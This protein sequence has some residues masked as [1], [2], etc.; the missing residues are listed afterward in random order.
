MK[1]GA[2]NN[3]RGL[4]FVVIVAA[5]FGSVISNNFMR[6]VVFADGEGDFYSSSHISN[7]TSSTAGENQSDWGTTGASNGGGSVETDVMMVCPGDSTSIT[8][9]HNV[10]SHGSASNVD[11]QVE[12]SGFTGSGFSVDVGTDENGNAVSGANSAMSIDGLATGTA[13]IGTDY[14]NSI[15]NFSGQIADESSRPYMDNETGSS[16]VHRDYY[17][18]TFDE[19]SAGNI[20]KFC[21]TMSVGGSSATSQACTTVSVGN[22]DGDGPPPPS[23]CGGSGNSTFVTSYVRNTSVGKFSSWSKTVYAKP[24][25]NLEWQ[26]CYFSGVQALAFKIVSSDAHKHSSSFEEGHYPQDNKQISSF[27]TWENRYS[28]SSNAGGGTSKSFGI[29]AVVSDM[30]KNSH[31]VSQGDVGAT[32]TETI[33]TG[34]PSS[35]S[36]SSPECGPWKCDS[37]D[38]NPHDCRCDEDGE[39]CDTCYDTCW[40]SCD[41]GSACWIASSR[42]GAVSDSASALVPYNF[43]H[44]SSVSLGQSTVFSGE[45]ANVTSFNVTI[46]PKYNSVTEGTYAT[47]DGGYST[48]LIGYASNT[49]SGGSLETYDSDICYSVP[50]YGGKCAVYSKNSH[51]TGIYNV[52]DVPAGKYF[53]V[54]AAVYP[55]SSGGDTNMSPTGSGTWWVS[56]PACAKIAKKPS[57]QIWGAGMYTADTIGLV[58][59]VK[60]VVSGKLNDINPKAGSN[61]IFGSW[62]EQNILANGKVSNLSS[63]AATGMAGSMKSRTRNGIDGSYFSSTLGNSAVCILSPLTMPNDKCTSLNYP[64][65]SAG[66]MNAPADKDA[67]TARFVDSSKDDFKLHN[68]CTISGVTQ[69][70]FSEKNTQVYKCNGTFTINENVV[71]FHN[72][73]KFSSLAEVPKIIIYAKNINIGCNVTQ[74]DAILIAD[75]NVNTCNNTN[76]NSQARANQLIINGSV[77]ANKMYANRTYGAAAGMNS[78]EPAEIINYDTSVYL[79]GSPRADISGSGKLETVYQTELSPRY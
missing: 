2:N 16:Y 78:D 32:L 39:N 50:V 73:L 43:L 3:K 22:C 58:N 53:C 55:A 52:Y 28:V 69:A 25:D 8:F 4:V 51:P 27:G 7:R 30:A 74:V 63:G 20:Y 65:G 37:Y 62:V 44:R 45:T 56:A 26:H 19:S 48:Q 9:S 17:N 34:S 64:G 33:K 68:A 76:A 36:I 10:Y 38:C 75:N 79:W 5:I 49:T 70:M 40:R 60:H 72:D 71:Y 23:G 29:G 61:I 47:R 41:H 54:V 57:I 46:E 13:N 1:D 59:A 6:N 24:G 12:R 77:I 21:E 18:I 67:L 66:S 42:G 35:A 11:W 31:T 15:Q 14:N